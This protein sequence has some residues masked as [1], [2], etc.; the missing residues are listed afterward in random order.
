MGWLF[1]KKKVPRVPLPP[2]RFMDEGS[3][4]F[5]NKVPVE[6]VIQP[7]K[8]KSGAGSRKPFAF[9]EEEETL[10]RPRTVPN[11][12][13]TSNLTPNPVVPMKVVEE[14]LYV[15]MEVY[16]R[17]LGELESLRTNLNK[18]HILTKELEKSEFNEENNFDKL[19]VD[20]KVV[21]DRLLHADKLLFKGD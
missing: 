10:G 11:F 1:G 3:L 8:I 13:S 4:S 7:E 15:K 16:Q 14:P 12:P 19:K 2:G 18:L 17:I 20:V 9:S 5:P 21:H 6:K